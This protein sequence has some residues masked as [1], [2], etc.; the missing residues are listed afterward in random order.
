MP[1]AFCRLCAV[2]GGTYFLSRSIEGIITDV[3]TNKCLGI[4]SNGQKINCQKIVLPGKL[5]P[6]SLKKFKTSESIYRKIVL[7][8]DS[9]SRSEKE[10]LTFLSI[11]NRQD[12]TFTFVTEVGHGASVCP[13]SMYCLHLVSNQEKIIDENLEKI[14]EDIRLWS[15]DFKVSNGIFET[16][17]ETL[18]L[19]SGPQFEVDYDQ[20]I[21]N[22]KNIY[23]SMFPEEPFLPRAPDP[24]EIILDFPSD[25]PNE[26]TVRGQEDTVEE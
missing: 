12:D 15:L 10:Q 13:K 18:Y 11:P 1:Q 23:Q 7:T 19:T 2:F 8:C 16:E 21:E 17:N 14:I 4:I 6:D 20:T 26:E 24:E 25:E 5:C 22:A 9:I 3:E